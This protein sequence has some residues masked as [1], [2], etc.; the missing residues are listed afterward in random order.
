MSVY[1]KN[2]FTVTPEQRA[3]RLRLAKIAEDNARQVLKR[4]DRTTVTR[5]PGTKRTITFDH[6]D[7]CWI[8]SKSG[9]YYYHPMNISK[10]NGQPIDFKISKEPS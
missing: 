7:G 3:E 2:I 1:E 10:L 5:C 6:W 4:G 9:I 8:V